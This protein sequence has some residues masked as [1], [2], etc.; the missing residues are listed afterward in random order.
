[1]NTVSD[2]FDHVGFM[3]QDDDWPNWPVL[4][5]KNYPKTGL[6]VSG[7]GP[8]VY[9]KNMFDSSLPLDEAETIEYSSLQ[10]VYDAGWRVD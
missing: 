5:I 7:G 6:L 4:P 8:T 3:A 9:L 10:E 2:E 1:M